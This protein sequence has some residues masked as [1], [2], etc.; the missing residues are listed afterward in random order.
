MLHAAAA[1]T[2]KMLAGMRDAAGAGRNDFKQIGALLIFVGIAKAYLHALAGQGASNEN[3]L[4]VP[5]RDAVS[6]RTKVIDG[7]LKNFAHV[8]LNNEGLCQ[9]YPRC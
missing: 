3:G 6:L 7:Q 2:R 1:A 5:M 9:F 8:S 4:T